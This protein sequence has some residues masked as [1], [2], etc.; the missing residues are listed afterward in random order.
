MLARIIF[1]MLL[2]V[3]T[4]A[5][6]PWMGTWKLI[7]G[8]LQAPSDRYKRTITKI[9]PWQGGIKVEYDMVGVRGGLNHL[10]W[11]GKFDGK[12]YPVEGAD[13]II[14]NAYTVIDD[15]HYEI[16]VKVEGHHTATARVEVSSD[17]KT[18]TTVTTEGDKKTTAVYERQ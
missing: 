5:Q 2:A 15:H 1:C 6:A 12:D 7:P 13:Y 8:K 3:G 16:L 11:T 4:N 14:T 9:E 10:E 17:G 18:L